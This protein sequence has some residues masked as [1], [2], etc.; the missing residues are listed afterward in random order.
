MFTK[1]AVQLRTMARE[2]EAL[3]MAMPSGPSG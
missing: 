3:I 1:L 2:V